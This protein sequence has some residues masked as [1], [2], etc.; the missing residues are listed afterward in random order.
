VIIFRADVV[1][2]LCRQ[3]AKQG[4]QSLLV[5]AESI[6]NRMN[7]DCPDL[8]RKLFE[9]VSTDRRGEVP[10]EAKPFMNNAGRLIHKT[11]SLSRRQ[12]FIAIAARSLQAQENQST[13][14]KTPAD[15]SS[16]EN[17]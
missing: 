17:T 9:P 15:N 16:A 14:Q 4:G 13:P 1:A 6:Y 5:S 8:L 2:L 3:D 11:P 12:E 7:A 10:R